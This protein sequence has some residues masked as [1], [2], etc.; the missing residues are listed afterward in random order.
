LHN[1]R[2]AYPKIAKNIIESYD[3][4]RI[5]SDHNQDLVGELYLAEQIRQ[6]EKEGKTTSILDKWSHLLYEGED[7]S[8]YKSAYESK[9]SD[10]N[11]K[12]PERR[13]SIREFTIN[14]ITKLN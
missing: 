9:G 6:L 8:R 12:V 4:S 1:L 13:V 7:E 11:S 14:N 10:I 2:S 5:V 3:G